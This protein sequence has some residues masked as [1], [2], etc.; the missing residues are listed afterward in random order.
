MKE[1]KSDPFFAK[2]NWDKI[3]LKKQTPINIEIVEDKSESV[4][5]LCRLKPLQYD[6]EYS[7]EKPVV[8]RVDN[9]SFSKCK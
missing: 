9:F 4:L 6:V 3:F 1:L 7:E 8:N 5:S 2:I